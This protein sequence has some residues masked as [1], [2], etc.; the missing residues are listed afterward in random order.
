MMQGFLECLAL[1]FL[2]AG[3]FVVYI[4]LASMPELL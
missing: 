1:A 2:V 4:F 3:L